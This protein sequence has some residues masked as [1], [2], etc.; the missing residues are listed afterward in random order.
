MESQVNRTYE[1]ATNKI[2]PYVSTL[3]SNLRK[4]HKDDLL[5]SESA[6]RYSNSD[7]EFCFI[8]PAP[9]LGEWVLQ[10]LG[11]GHCSCQHLLWQG[12]C[13]GW[14][15]WFDINDW[16]SYLKQKWRGA[17]GWVLWISSPL[18]V[19]SL[20]FVLASASSHS[21]KSSIGFLL[22]FAEPFLTNTN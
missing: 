8:P 22:G 16:K 14:C 20:V 13:D 19:A 10:R 5:A 9:A 12:H 3:P 11:R 4:R 2:P 17:S 7:F 18:L 6:V 1:L 21:S 15:I